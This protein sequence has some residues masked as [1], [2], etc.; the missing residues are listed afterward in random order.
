MSWNPCFLERS[1]FLPS[2]LLFF[3]PRLRLGQCLRLHWIQWPQGPEPLSS[4]RFL[5]EPAE[6]PGFQQEPLESALLP[7]SLPAPLEHAQGLR[8]LSPSTQ[9]QTPDQR[10]P[11]Q[12]NELLWA[13]DKQ[14][15]RPKTQ[16]RLALQRAE[17]AQELAS[18]LE[19]RL[20]LVPVAGALGAKALGAKVLDW[21]QASP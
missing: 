8:W 7:W 9:L 13:A 10:L 1:G 6:V 3:F 15:V 16:R 12:R 2:Q 21:L 4:P 5:L 11:Y 19:Q 18:G 17:Q 14:A 20:V